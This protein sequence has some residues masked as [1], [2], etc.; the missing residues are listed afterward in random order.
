VLS[1]E[2]ANRTIY[3]VNS[4]GGDVL[5]PKAGRELPAVR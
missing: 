2:G 5:Q 4:G 1:A 3:S